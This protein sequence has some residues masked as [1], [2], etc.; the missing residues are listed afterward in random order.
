MKNFLFAVIAVLY[1]VIVVA[2]AS[3]TVTVTVV[4]EGPLSV[5]SVMDLNL[6]KIISGLSCR[7]LIAAIVFRYWRC[8]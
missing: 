3:E 1:C 7:H 4:P 8:G 2:C 6:E 5:I